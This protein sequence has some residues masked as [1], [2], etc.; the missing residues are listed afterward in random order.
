MADS[1]Q[2]SK[3]RVLPVAHITYDHAQGCQGKRGELLVHEH[4]RKE[5]RTNMTRT[6]V[7]FTGHIA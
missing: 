5:T 6:S 2:F 4:F 1:F 3:Q 7:T